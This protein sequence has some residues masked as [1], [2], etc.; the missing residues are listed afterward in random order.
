MGEKFY[1]TIIAR[2]QERKKRKKENK[3]G[4]RGWEVAWRQTGRGRECAEGRGE[5]GEKRRGFLKSRESEDLI[6]IQTSFIL[7]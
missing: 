4:E 7:I 2:I 5:S 1:S 6:K 3:E